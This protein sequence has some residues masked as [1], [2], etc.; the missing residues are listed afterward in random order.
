MRVPSCAVPVERLTDALSRELN[1]LV[2]DE[3]GL[4]GEYDFVLQTESEVD[5]KKMFVTPLAP[6]VGQIG[7]KL[8]S[9]K[10]AVEFYTIESIQHPSEN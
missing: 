8:E 2:V 1:R 4:I 7:L 10:G 9:R 3:T 6:S 5:E